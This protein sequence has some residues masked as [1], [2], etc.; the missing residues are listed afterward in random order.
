MPKL[1]QSIIQI[2]VSEVAKLINTN[3]LWAGHVS[4]GG[5]SK[6]V[7]SNKTMPKQLLFWTSI[8]YDLN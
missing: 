2:N 3:R 1:E 8:F 4:Q 7:F 6:T 5:R